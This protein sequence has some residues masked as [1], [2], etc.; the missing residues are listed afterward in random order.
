MDGPTCPVCA[1]P[2]LDNPRGRAGDPAY[3][4]P[5]DDAAHRAAAAS[6]KAECE[7]LLRAAR[8]QPPGPTLELLAEIGAWSRPDMKAV[9]ADPVVA[10]K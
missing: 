6:R 7:A 5:M 8:E 2:M 1:R 9:E 10:Q 3:V 4:C